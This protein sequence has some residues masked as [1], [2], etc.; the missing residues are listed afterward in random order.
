DLTVRQ[1]AA[2]HDTQVAVVVAVIA[3]GV[4]LFPSLALLFRLTLARR[5]GEAEH[6]EK[7]AGRPGPVP[8]ASGPT[9]R[10]AAGALVAG[11]GFLTVANAAAAHAIGIV[12][13]LLFV[14]F[15]FRAALPR[16]LGA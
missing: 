12:F 8:R 15:G 16:D 4:I 11:I 14:A 3:G 10:V 7:R 9:G 2:G 5:L 6:A 1:A 13:F